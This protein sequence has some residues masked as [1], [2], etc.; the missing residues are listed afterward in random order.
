MIRRRLASD[1]AS[2][3]MTGRQLACQGVAWQGR[4]SV[5]R[6]G[7]QLA[8]EGVGWQDRA[9]VGRIGRQVL[10]ERA[11]LVLVHGLWFMVNV[12]WLMIYD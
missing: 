11:R 2:V 5:G 7:R 1:R 6:K 9:S 10:R 4:A 12:L 3:G 8:G